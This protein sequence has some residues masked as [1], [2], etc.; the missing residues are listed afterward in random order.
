MAYLPNYP[1][2]LAFFCRMP[3]VTKGET[4]I[5]D[6]RREHLHVGVG[7]PPL[8]DDDSPAAGKRLEDLVVLVDTPLRARRSAPFVLDD[9]AVQVDDVAGRRVRLRRD[10]VQDRGR[11]GE[12][13]E[14]EA[15]RAQDY[16]AHGSAA[17]A[18]MIRTG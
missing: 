15:Q 11:R 2:R 3:S 8:A 5:G 16:G 12:S 17:H 10:R 13:P 7:G 1:N 18:G 4:L 9:L 14:A 6:V